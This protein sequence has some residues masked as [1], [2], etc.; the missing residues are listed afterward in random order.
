MYFILAVTG[1]GRRWQWRSM[2]EE[3]CL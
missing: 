1:I 2:P 3:I